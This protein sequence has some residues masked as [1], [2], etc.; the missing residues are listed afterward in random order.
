MW[1]YVRRSVHTLSCNDSY[2]NARPYVA[3][4]H[5]EDRFLTCTADGFQLFRT[6]NLC[7]LHTFEDPG[8]LPVRHPCQVAFVEDGR[9]IVAGTD[10]GKVLIFD[11]DVGLLEQTLMYPGGKMVQT[12]ATCTG[13]HGHYV[14]MAGTSSGEPSDV[15]VWFKKVQPRRSRTTQ[16]QDKVLTPQRSITKLLCYVSVGIILT[17]SAIIIALIEPNPEVFNV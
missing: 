15:I 13:P 6:S 9:K 7:H 8:T 1:A 3:L 12:V 17:A 11:G 4:D 10:Q 14:A 2:S 16:M 5:Y